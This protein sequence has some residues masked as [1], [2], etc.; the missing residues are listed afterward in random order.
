[1]VT[2]YWL[3][4]YVIS[5]A[6]I[7]II[8]VIVSS[9]I[10]NI[11]FLYIFQIVIIFGLWY[12]ISPL[13]MVFLLKMRKSG[14]EVAKT[15]EKVSKE[16]GIKT[17]HVYISYVDFPNALAFGNIFF[18]GMAVT[19]PLL[20]LLNDQELEAV[21]A[22]E[23]SHLKNHD[24]EM[25]ILSIMGINSVYSIL[26]YFFPCYIELIVALY[27]LGLFPLF[28]AIHRK[29]EK[30]ADITAVKRDKNF[31]VPLETALIKI[32]YLSDKLPSYV[33]KNFPELQVLLM[34]YDIISSNYGNGGLFRTHP[35]LSER[36]RYLSNYE[37]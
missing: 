6:S 14:E 31:A 21:I 12:L 28:F 34:K 29:V 36:L 10:I 19:S 33:L 5:F 32:A 22:H 13:I 3:R 1:M 37:Y 25:L 17:P 30:R 24:P 18:R 7:A 2:R 11:P 16:F 8:D 27:F 9:I 35:S 15:V 26:I 23:I 20:D 4:Y